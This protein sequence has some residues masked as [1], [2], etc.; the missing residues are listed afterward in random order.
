M[1]SVILGFV[2]LMSACAQDR[3]VTNRAKTFCNPLDLSYR[4]Q[5]DDPA[6]REAAD[7]TVIRY[8]D[9]Y[10]L[11]ASMS[12]GYWF[13]DDLLSW[14]FVETNEIPTEEYA[15]TAVVIEGEVFFMASSGTK[16]TIYRSND[17]LN[18]HWTVALDSLALTVWDPAFFLD[19]DE[20]LYLYWGCS[21]H[22]PIQGIELDYKNGFS[23][24]GKPKD[25]LVAH[26]DIF[27][28]EVCG[29]DNTLYS[30][31]PY[32]EGAWVNKYKNKY[33]LQYAGP[34]TEYKSYADGVFTSENPLGPYV[35]AEHN[36]FAYKP[37]GFAS[38]AGH[39]STFMDEYGNYWH[40]GTVS[41]S[42]KH[43]FERRIAMY[44]TF[45]DNDGILFADT[46]YGDYPIKVPSKKVTGT[47]GYKTGWMLLSYGKTVRASSTA[48]A[49][50]P[51]SAVTDENI[52][53]YWAAQTGN[54]N[55]WISI[56]L[57][58][59]CKVEAIQVNFAEHKAEKYKRGNNL[60]HQYVVEASANG[61]E[62]FTLIDYSKNENDKTH[63][64][65][66]LR[67]STLCRYVRLKNVAVPN[68]KLAISGFRIFGSARKESPGE[69]NKLHVERSR[70]NL[71]QA[72]LEWNKA[73]DA[74]GYNICYGQEGSKLYQNII[75]YGD[76]VFT[77]NSLSV[78]SNYC[79]TVESFN[80]S[81][82]MSTAIIECDNINEY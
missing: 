11:F 65:A 71:R 34:G 57:G 38:G 80:E 81:G 60:Y 44:P 21:D 5:L 69:V 10:I 18:G 48:Q 77:I 24:I 55:E 36:P 31:A 76:T 79:F 61:D 39:G 8:K 63:A 82:T 46:K 16:S 9:K 15:P 12:G 40:V 52:R 66:V 37:K 32:I 6:R 73:R 75:V 28:W 43:I 33:Y 3:G 26:P 78:L 30:K 47:D 50:L 56:D 72:T 2:I 23:L 58:S 67:K 7:P 25:L 41:I 13:S 74:I 35:I 19:E 62:W 1:S 51:P 59:V 20:R 64:Y 70:K 14:E 22:E 42:E 29:D 45:F 68:G 49:S 4:Y 54:T 53:T 17:P 27:G